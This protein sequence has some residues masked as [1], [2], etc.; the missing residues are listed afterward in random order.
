MN[1]V[2]TNRLL[3]RPWQPDDEEELL[4]LWDDPAVRAGRDIPRERILAIANDTLRQ[5]ADIGFGAWAAIEKTTGQWIGRVGLDE[6]SD[7]PGTHRIEV[8]FEI[9]RP[10]WGRGLATEGAIAA[11]RFGF[12]D[13]GLNQVISTTAHT[14]IAARRVMEKA[15]LTYRGALRW[16]DAEVVWYAA[17]RDDWNAGSTPSTP[18]P[19]PRASGTPTRTGR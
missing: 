8:G 11:L 15:G 7:W 9:A 17:D 2:E 13:H 10:W 6:L 12:E 5:W 14:N 18:M 19:R 3:L 1:T 16:R 4:H